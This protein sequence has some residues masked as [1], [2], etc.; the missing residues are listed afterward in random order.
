M[1]PAI[2]ELPALKTLNVKNNKVFIKFDNIG[3]AKKLEVLY[4]SNIDIGSIDGI[5]KAPSLREL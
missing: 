1:P 4:I 2:F 3:K 5:G